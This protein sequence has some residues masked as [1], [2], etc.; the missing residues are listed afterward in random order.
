MLGQVQ[1]ADDLLGE[2]EVV[3][4]GE[5]LLDQVG[6]GRAQPAG[7][8]HRAVRGVGAQFGQH[9]R[10]EPL[11]AVRGGAGPGAGHD[12]AGDPWCGAVAQQVEVDLRV[13]EV[14]QPFRGSGRESPAPGGEYVQGLRIAPGEQPVEDGPRGAVVAQQVGG[15]HPG[16]VRPETGQDGVDDLRVV[17][18]AE[19]GADRPDPPAVALFALPDRLVGGARAVRGE[20]ASAVLQRPVRHRGCGPG[21][22][23]PG[24]LQQLHPAEPVRA[25]AVLD[26]G[27]GGCG[28]GEVQ[29]G[30]GVGAELGAQ[31]AGGLGPP[32]HGEG[33]AA[34]VERELE[35]AVCR[36]QV[37]QLF[38]REDALVVGGFDGIRGGGRGRGDGLPQLREGGCGAP[39]AIG[40]FHAVGRAG[41]DEPLRGGEAGGVVPAVVGEEVHRAGVGGQRDVAG[42]DGAQDVQGGEGG[43][44]AGGP[45]HLGRLGCLGYF[46]RPVRGG[47][48][49]LGG[50]G[51]PCLGDDLAQGARVPGQEGV[52]R[53]PGLRAFA[54]PGA[55]ELAEFGQGCAGEQ[56]PPGEPVQ[57]VQCVNRRGAVW[58]SWAGSRSPAL[59][60]SSAHRQAQSSSSS[61][62]RRCPGGVVFPARRPPAR[63][64]ALRALSRKASRWASSAASWRAS[65]SLAFGMKGDFAWASDR[66]SRSWTYGSDSRSRRLLVPRVVA[67]RA[68]RRAGSS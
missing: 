67:S 63:Q 46:V 6:F 36:K 68:G 18:Q 27:R 17:G 33:E 13:A 21:F 16:S 24:Q 65:S 37:H 38:R 12:P 62:V 25:P 31:Q 54:E 41:V 30:I 43:P 48:V 32:G 52:E 23:G 4:P 10:P 11:R 58:I 22:P 35:Y 40:G 60:M 50:R 9:P 45:R 47:A 59:A 53:G 7:T 15:E 51:L 44:V 2:A 8:S 49:A 20:G 39:G 14:G 66:A 55:G 64:V 57:G 1:A 3:A 19:Q 34:P 28:L 5:D 61:S 26:S 42:G 56:L 29:P